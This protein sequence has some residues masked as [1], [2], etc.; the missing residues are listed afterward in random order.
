MN[1]KKHI[2][3]FYG[4]KIKKFF[5]KQPKKSDQFGLEESK[6][7]SHMP[8]TA[9]SGGGGGNP[10]IFPTPNNAYPNQNNV[11]LTAQMNNMSLNNSNN[12][13]PMMT[14]AGILDSNPSQQGGGGGNNY[15]NRRFNQSFNSPR[16]NSYGNNGGGGGYNNGYSGSGGGGGG[17][18]HLNDWGRPMAADADL[19]K[20]AY[21]MQFLL[22]LLWWT[23]REKKFI[24]IVLQLY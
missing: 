12:T 3:I 7:F 4:L 17:G 8:V 22:L 21:S 9:S 24:L 23:E 10:N 18:A 2:K 11:D 16:M 6:S 19:E 5:F 20:Y 14:H 15:Y 1:L 13:K